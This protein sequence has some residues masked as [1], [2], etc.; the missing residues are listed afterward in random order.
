MCQIHIWTSTG[1]FR[2]CARSSVPLSATH[3]K[4]SSKVQPPWL[5]RSL[6][7]HIDPQGEG[8]YKICD[9]FLMGELFL[10]RN[11]QFPKNKDCQ[12]ASNDIQPT[13]IL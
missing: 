12:A 9:C 2:G 13:A 3:Q 4:G 1:I 7:L 5:V 6:P 11:L 10:A 8:Q